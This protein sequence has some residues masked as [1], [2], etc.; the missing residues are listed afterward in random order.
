MESIKNI[1]V[2]FPTTQNK[3]CEQQG[4]LYL[5]FF[6]LNSKYIVVKKD[7]FSKNC[8]YLCLRTYLQNTP[9][10]RELGNDHAYTLVYKSDATR[11]GQII[12]K[13]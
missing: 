10:F 1:K 6:F 2:I 9:L 5:F 12:Q 7:P 3:L 13:Y 11:P 8:I 4:E